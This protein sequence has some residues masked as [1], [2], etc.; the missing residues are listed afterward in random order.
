MN[1]TKKILPI[2]IILIFFA[3]ILFSEVVQDPGLP[4]IKCENFFSSSLYSEV[5]SLMI[6][7][8][9][10][11]IFI[12]VI[13]YMV[14]NLLKLNQL[15]EKV[16]IEIRQLL[17]TILIG[18]FIFSIAFVIDEV[19]KL[20]FK[21]S[22]FDISSDYLKRFICLSTEV[23]I[24]LEGLRAMLQYA[25]GLKARYY[26][27]KYGWGFAVQQFPGLDIML[28]R[29]LGII[30][31]ILFPFTSSLMVQSIGLEIIRAF[32]MTLLLPAGIVLRLIPITRNAS[33]FLIATSFSL[34][35]ILP[36]LY[37]IEAKVVSDMYK[38][39][40]QTDICSGEQIGGSYKYTSY[41]MIISTTANLLPSF[42]KDLWSFF[43]HISYLILQALVLPS[44]NMIIVITAIQ[45]LTKFLNMGL[46]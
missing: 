29:P 34:F 42:E 22:M 45:T 13:G 3:N 26:A 1:R 28:E 9:A 38:N 36:F 24:K 12:I 41:D 8:S 23:N 11:M 32:A 5:S 25:S 35:F 7:L 18:L 4:N 40:F 19:I 21:T 14:A 43:E 39:S 31:L 44:L 20:K 10:T 6:V 16:K 33:S 30:S 46:E 17:I 15:I 2:I 27:H 37:V